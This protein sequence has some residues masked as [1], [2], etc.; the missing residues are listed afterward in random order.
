MHSM[1]SL[2]RT[3]CKHLHCGDTS[4][5]RLNY[6]ES[7]FQNQVHKTNVHAEPHA[8]SQEKGL[9]GIPTAAHGSSPH[10]KHLSHWDVSAE[11]AAVSLAQPTCKKLGL[12][13]A[14]SFKNISKPH[15]WYYLILD[16]GAMPGIN[17]TSQNAA[18]FSSPHKDNCRLLA[19]HFQGH[20][21]T[22]PLSKWPHIS[23]TKTKPGPLDD[24]NFK[25][26][27]TSCVCRFQSASIMI[28]SS[29]WEEASSIWEILE[30][31]HYELSK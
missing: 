8:E 21:W 26:A 12:H 18:F 30:K 2:K 24:T 16:F 15:L 13:S 25:T 28:S 22:Q 19:D 10:Q 23:T 5:S 7:T 6:L 20:L 3:Q 27:S 4:Q 9:K 17:F 31:S 14:N 29:Y 11:W 1:L